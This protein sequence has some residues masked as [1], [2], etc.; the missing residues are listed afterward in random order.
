VTKNRKPIDDGVTFRFVR[1][2]PIRKQRGAPA[3]ELEIEDENNIIRLW[4]DEKDLKRNV[5]LYG[6]HEALLEAMIAYKGNEPIPR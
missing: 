1:Y 4:M 6:P 5:Q 2:N 3:A